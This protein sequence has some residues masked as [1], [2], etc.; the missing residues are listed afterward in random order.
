MVL[1][2]VSLVDNISEMVYSTKVLIKNIIISVW[3]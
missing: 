3:S 2:W 1:V